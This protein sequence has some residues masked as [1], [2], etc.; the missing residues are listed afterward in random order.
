[1][2]TTLT[3]TMFKDAF[4]ACG[5]NDQFS[6]AGLSALFNFIEEMDEACDTETELDVIGLCCEF[7]EYDSAIDCIESAGYTCLIDEDYEG[8]IEE[9]FLNHLNENTCVIEFEG[10]III[11]DF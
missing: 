11:Q 1:M 2:K 7:T 10:G 5:R 6:Y 8:G 3:E 9:Y 4:R